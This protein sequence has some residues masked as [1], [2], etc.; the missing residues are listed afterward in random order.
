MRGL[1]AGGVFVDSVC[2]PAKA[3]LKVGH[4]ELLAS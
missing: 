2:L 3:D 1:L 4:Y